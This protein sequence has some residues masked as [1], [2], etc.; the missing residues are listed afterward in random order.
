M[1]CVNRAENLPTCASLPGR[2]KDLDDQESW[3]DF[4]E[5]YWKL[6]YNTAVRA[7]LSH[8]DAEEVVQE[9]VLTVVR[10]ID[11]L[12]YDPAIGSFKGWLLN[13]VRWRIADQ[14]R[15]NAARREVVAPAEED[16]DHPQLWIEQVPDQFNWEEVWE[17][18]WRQNLLDA[19]IERC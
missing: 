7:G 5:T 14:F 17:L 2:L 16:G 6:I 3:R 13:T 15:K 18:D 1:T 4:F 12:K 9:T 10:R 8:A 19:A 11:S